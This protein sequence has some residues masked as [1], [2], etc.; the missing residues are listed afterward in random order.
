ME[1]LD[2]RHIGFRFSGKPPKT[3]PSDTQTLIRKTHELSADRVVPR[4]NRAV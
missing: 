3:G 1:A 4:F 2:I